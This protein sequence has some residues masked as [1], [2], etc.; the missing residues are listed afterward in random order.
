MLYQEMGTS[1]LFITHRDIA[2]HGFLQETLS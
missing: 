2:E 1:I